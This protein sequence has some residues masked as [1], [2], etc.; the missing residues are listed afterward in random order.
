MITIDI[1][2]YYCHDFQTHFLNWYH[3]EN[4]LKLTMLT[5]FFQVRDEYRSDFDPGR[6]G[7]GKK[8]QQGQQQATRVIS[9]PPVA[10]SKR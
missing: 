3:K 2:F 8:V 7:L 9:S 5:L 1:K 10:Y 6:G 4:N